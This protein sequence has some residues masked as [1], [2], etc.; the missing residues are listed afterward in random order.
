MHLTAKITGT[1]KIFLTAFQSR[2][3]SSGTQVYG[4]CQLPSIKN[5][6][7]LRHVYLTK[8]DLYPLH[9]IQVRKNQIK[10]TVAIIH[11]SKR[12]Q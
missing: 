1:M 3:T 5:H 2:P 10:K 8:M 12:K 9:S 4:L 6:W 11:K 7:T